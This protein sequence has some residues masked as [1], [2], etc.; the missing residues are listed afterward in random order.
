MPLYRAYYFV[1]LLLIRRILIN[2]VVEPLHDSFMSS[3][4]VFLRR[5]NLGCY[6]HLLIV[7]I[8]WL[9]QIAELLSEV[10][11]VST[12]FLFFFLLLLRQ[13]LLV[14]ILLD[15]FFLFCLNFIDHVVDQG[16]IIQLRFVCVFVLWFLFLLLGLFFG[17]RQGHKLSRRRC[18]TVGK[19]G[20]TWQLTALRWWLWCL[21]K[22]RS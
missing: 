21:G 8:L 18:G 13:T 12:L 7:T 9:F 22:F 5:V 16:R 19:G 4:Y 15:F 2:L 20:W 17:G 11:E 14:L 6:L 3:F 1:C 10:G